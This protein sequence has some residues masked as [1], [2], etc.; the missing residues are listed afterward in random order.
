MCYFSGAVV[1]C[2]YAQEEGEKYR[3]SE[4]I[5]LI[6]EGILFEVV[7][8]FTIKKSSL[9]FKFNYSQKMQSY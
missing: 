7:S 9:D 4:V 5:Y 6:E 8:F 1:I 3:Q 2:N